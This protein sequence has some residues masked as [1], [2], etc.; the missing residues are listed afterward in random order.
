MSILP[1]YW[2]RFIA[3]NRLEDGKFSIPWSDFDSENDRH[4]IYL[5]DESQAQEE[6]TELWPG[7]RVF[8][9]GFVPVAGDEIGTGDQ[10]FINTN[11]GPDG[12]LYQ[13]DHEQV[14]EDG[15]D[16]ADAVHV[17]LASYSELVRFR[18]HF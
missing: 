18:T 8:E 11:D 1:E 2:T 14:L 4:E 7:M 17:V 12:P 9:D 15:Y 16:R 13:I 5:F 6:A 10:Y 3:E